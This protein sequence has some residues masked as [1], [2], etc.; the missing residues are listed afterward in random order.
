MLCYLIEDVQEYNHTVEGGKGMY[1]YF[2]GSHIDVGARPDAG[3]HATVYRQHS[4]IA[5][6][7]P[8]II[9]SK[10]FAIEDP[11]SLNEGP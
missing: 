10:V 9:I 8:I 2:M 5:N 1:R 11:S 3:M 6:V 7:L 4:L